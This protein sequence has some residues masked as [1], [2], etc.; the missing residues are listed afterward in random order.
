MIEHTSLVSLWLPILVSAAI[1]FVASSIIH[2]F[3]PWHK[4]DFPKLANESQVLDA[5]RPLALAPGDYLVPRASSMEEMK[6]PEFAANRARGPVVMMTV[7]RNGPVNMGPTFVQWFLYLIVVGIFTAYVAG[8]ALP[9]GTD[10]MD[11]FCLAGTT[12]FL[13]YALAL[14]QISIWYSRSWSLTLKSMLDGLIYGLLT[15]GTF[16]A[17][18][19]HA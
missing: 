14:P 10:Y 19:P 1:V 4:S 16:G 17:F 11:V 6:S 15:A 9:P 13:A 3:L 7:M 5:L 18:W 12:A 2:M 8:R